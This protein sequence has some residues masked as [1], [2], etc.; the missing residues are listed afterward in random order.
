M[1]AINPLVDEAAAG[2]PIYPRIH[3]TKNLYAKQKQIMRRN[4]FLGC[5]TVLTKPK[6]SFFW[7][8]I[9][10]L[11]QTEINKP[12]QDLTNRKTHIYLSF[13]H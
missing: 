2:L 9:Q 1:I 13:Y 7:F 12:D 3:P 11:A 8:R 10:L 5:N 6:E 4:A